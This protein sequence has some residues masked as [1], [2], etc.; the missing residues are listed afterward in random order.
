MY[1]GWYLGGRKKQKIL[2]DKMTGEQMLLLEAFGMKY[3]NGELP[4][5]FYVVWMTVQVIALYKNKGT[6][7]LYGGH[8]SKGKMGGT[9]YMR[10]KA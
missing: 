3:V 8:L 1:V 2:A 7:Q 5:W 4:E 9:L 10:R 6:P